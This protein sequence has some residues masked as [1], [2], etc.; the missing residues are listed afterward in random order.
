MICEK[1]KL[2]YLIPLIGKKMRQDLDELV[3]DLYNIIINEDQQEPKPS[4]TEN[5]L[6]EKT[7]RFKTYRK[8]LLMSTE[9]EIK[10]YLQYLIK[11]IH[12][13]MLIVNLIMEIMKDY[14]IN[15]LKTI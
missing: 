12:K 9:D 13:R 8:L 1:K 3:V 5:T 7:Y 11:R 10:S 15:P 2:I 4:T 14:L 6:L